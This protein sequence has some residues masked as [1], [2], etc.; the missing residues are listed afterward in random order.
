MNKLTWRTWSN[1]SLA[2]PIFLGGADGEGKSVGSAL[3]K[4]MLDSTRTE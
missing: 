4:A 3:N 2:C 1:A